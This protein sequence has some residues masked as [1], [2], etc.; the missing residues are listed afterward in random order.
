MWIDIKL[1]V[2]TVS[3]FESPVELQHIS[4]KLTVDSTV[5]IEEI[6]TEAYLATVTTRKLL[7][8]EQQNLIGQQCSNC[9]TWYTV[10]EFYKDSHQM[11]NRTLTCKYCRAKVGAQFRQNNPTYYRKYKLEHREHLSEQYRQWT[12]QNRSRV[13]ESQ[14]KTSL[15]RKQVLAGIPDDKQYM[16][17]LLEDRKCV[18]T[19]VTEKVALDHI[20][21]VSVGNWG[22]RKGNLQWMY[23]RLNIS[24]GS[25]DIFDWVDSMEQ[26]RLD[27]LLP[28]HVGLTIAEF[29]Q[30]VYQSLTVKAAE[31]GLTF[32]QY[33][34]KYLEEYYREE[35]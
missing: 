9:G 6:N 27:Y 35:Q 29:K 4:N 10:N 22:N 23:E 5:H 1:T 25:K 18:I 31:I 21:P 19:G 16:S 13:A 30:R 17:Q 24:K 32:E 2:T 26:E 15:R 28:E 8:N 20:M 11:F 14:R 33:K 34:Q 12:T 7:L 3:K